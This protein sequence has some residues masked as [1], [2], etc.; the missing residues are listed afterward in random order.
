VLAASEGRILVGLELSRALRFDYGG[1]KTYRPVRTLRLTL[2]LSGPGRVRI[3]LGR[4]CDEKRWE[5]SSSLRC[6]GRLLRWLTTV[7]FAQA[8]R[9]RY[10]HRL[11]VPSGRYFIRFVP[12]SPTGVPQPSAQDFP[13]IVR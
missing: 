4:G 1:L 13:M 11:D 5:S 7:R 8:A 12:E 3:G 6:S 10:V 9:N 2:A